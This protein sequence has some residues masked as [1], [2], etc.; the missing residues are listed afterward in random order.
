MTTADHQRPDGELRDLVR[1]IVPADYDAVASASDQISGTLNQLNIPEQKRMEICMAVQEA[2]VNAVKHGCDNDATKKV[3]CV[4]QSGGDGRIII[5]VR[6]PGS[7]FDS[8]SIPDPKGDDNLHLSHGR[9]VYLIR[10]LMD[11]VRFNPTGSEIRMW[12]Y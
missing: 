5:I 8:S 10:Q 4:M 12:K 6:D 3:S 11:E 9:G 7:G 2:L 1:L